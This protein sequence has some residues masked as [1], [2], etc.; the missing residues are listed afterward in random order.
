MDLHSPYVKWEELYPEK[1]DLATAT[2]SWFKRTSSRCTLVNGH[3]I[4]FIQEDATPNKLTIINGDDKSVRTIHLDGDPEEEIWRHL[5]DLGHK[6]EEQEPTESEESLVEYE[7]MVEVRHASLEAAEAALTEAEDALGEQIFGEAPE[8]KTITRPS[9]AQVKKYLNLSTAVPGEC[10]PSHID[11]ADVID[12]LQHY[13]KFKVQVESEEDPN[14]D[15]LSQPGPLAQ[16]AGKAA[17]LLKSS[18]GSYMPT[19]GHHEMAEKLVN[20]ICQNRGEFEGVEYGSIAYYGVLGLMDSVFRDV[21]AMVSRNHPQFPTFIAQYLIRDIITRNYDYLQIQHEGGARQ[22]IV[23]LM[24]NLFDYDLSVQL[25]SYDNQ[26]KF[27][28]STEFEIKAMNIEN[29]VTQQIGIGNRDYDDY[30][31]NYHDYYDNEY[32]W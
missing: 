14:L 9:L 20:A 5:A 24:C 26:S 6:P 19:F 32:D 18:D 4:L 12:N 1:V 28:E 10:D 22:Y 31:D 17:L 23:N 16:E 3:R 21:E 25:I 15:G 8:L 7:P 27:D 30:Y 13:K 11:T 2:I 29:N